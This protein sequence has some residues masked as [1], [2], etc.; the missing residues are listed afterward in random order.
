VLPRLMPWVLVCIEA[1]AWLHRQGLH[2]GDIRADHI[3]I[4]KET[5][6][7]VWIDFDYE[8]R[9]ADYDVFCLGNLL[10]Q[11]V[12]KGRHS[13]HDIGLRPSD[14]PGLGGTLTASDMS[15]MFR[16]RVA[17]LRKLFPHISTDLNEVLMRFSAG[18]TDHYRDVH[19]LLSDL[20]ALFP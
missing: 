11:V 19:A 15:L 16:H 6:N 4:N 9:P 14:Y 5:G 20:R 13:V 18:S 2:H 3:L 1:I 17:N 10:L 8:V 12:G 7:Y